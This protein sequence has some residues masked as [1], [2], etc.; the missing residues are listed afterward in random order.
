[1]QSDKTARTVASLN[2]SLDDLT[3]HAGRLRGQVNKQR[4]GMQKLILRHK[5]DIN[6]FGVRWLSLSG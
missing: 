1:M 6:N 5:T 3:T 2:A 4:Q